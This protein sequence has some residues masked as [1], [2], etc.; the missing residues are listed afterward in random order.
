MRFALRRVAAQGS[1][2]TV[3][4]GSRDFSDCPPTSR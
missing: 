1:V 2:V 4:P 3:E